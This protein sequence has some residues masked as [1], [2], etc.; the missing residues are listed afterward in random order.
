MYVN[1]E[2][3]STIENSMMGGGMGGHGGMMGEG[4]PGGMGGRHGEFQDG[5][6]QG[7]MSMGGTTQGDVMQG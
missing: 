7:D 1:G 2:Q 4:G 6:P 3:V 5:G